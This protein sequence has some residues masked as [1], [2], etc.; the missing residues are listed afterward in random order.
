M[1]ATARTTTTIL[2]GAAFALLALTGCSGGAATPTP[3]ETTPAAVEGQS[4]T[5][6]CTVLQEGIM[7]VS[8]AISDGL[9]GAATDPEASATAI[10]DATVAFAATV[11]GIDNAEVKDA[12]TTASEGFTSLSEQFTIA[13]TDPENADTDA[14]TAAQDDV[15]TSVEALSEICS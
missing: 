3:V 13:T 12:A 1:I 10:S 2:A 11:E 14:L 8:T 7:E 4:T 6:A 5:D 9:Q 15:K